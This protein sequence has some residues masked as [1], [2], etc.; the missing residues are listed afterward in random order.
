MKFMTFRGSCA[1]AGVANMLERFGVNVTDQ[2]IALRMKL[3]WLFAK[4]DGIYLGGAMLQSAKWFDL[5]LRSIG[6]TMQE[7]EIARGD[8]PAALHT[9][10][11]AMIGLH[12]SEHDKHAVVYMGYTDGA[13]AFVNNRREQS[14]EIETLM[15]TE[16]ELLD[17]LDERA[18]VAVLVPASVQQANF[19]PLFHQSCLVLK[20]MKSDME[21][22][23][24]REQQPQELIAAMNPLFR[25]I[26]L[27]GVT[28]LEL[29]GE[30]ALAQKLQA[31]QGELINAVRMN[32]PLVPV[33]HLSFPLLMEAIS[34]YIALI[35]REAA[36]LS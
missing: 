33:R 9:E 11:C 18:H 25:A 14:D 3:P 1:F 31:V 34:Q 4:E 10:T 2:E 8:V 16:A 13:Y 22:F 20:E 27:D 6:L 36:R 12:L 30:N 5:Y 21:A 15:L 7:R 24:C 23:C 28:M 17:K 19:A 26:L 35:Q 32:Q 29:I